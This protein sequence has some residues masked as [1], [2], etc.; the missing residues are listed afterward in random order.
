MLF[1]S[2]GST[3]GAGTETARVHH[4]HR[5][6]GGSMAG[7]D[8]NYLYRMMKKHGIARKE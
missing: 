7:I 1:L 4:A 8:R 3:G 6:R 2:F 5:R